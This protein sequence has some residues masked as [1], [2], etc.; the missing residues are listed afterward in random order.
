MWEKIFPPRGRRI[1]A[2][3]HNIGLRSRKLGVTTSSGRFGDARISRSRVISRL[4]PRTVKSAKSIGGQLWVAMFAIGVTNECQACQRRKTAHNRKKLPTGHVP[5]QRPFE[6]IS[7]DLVDYKLEWVSAAGIRCRYVLSMMDHMI[8]FALF[9]PLPNKSATTVAQAINDRIIGIFGSQEM[10]HSDQGPE[11]ENSVTQQLQHIVNFK[12]TRKTPYRPQG[13]SVSERVHSTLHAMLAM[14]SSMN[15][16][17]WASLLPF[18]QLA[19]NTSYSSTMHETPFFLL[20][21]VD[22]R[23][24]L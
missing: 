9:V 12:M 1:C 5:L 11:F 17:N 24:S 13:N 19:Y 7:V 20:C 3:F 14:H 10:L 23:D 22:N 21:L 2:S 16:D 4:D 18:I 15:R 8:R 6:R